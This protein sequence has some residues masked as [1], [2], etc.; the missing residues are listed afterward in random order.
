MN[1]SRLLMKVAVGYSLYSRPS[2]IPF[3]VLRTRRAE[4]FCRF[5]TDAGVRRR[6]EQ[7]YA[8]Q[9]T[10]RVRLVPHGITLFLW[11]ATACPCSPGELRIARIP[12]KGLPCHDRSTE[13]Q[14]P[15]ST[16]EFFL[17]EILL[18]LIWMILLIGT[19]SPARED[20][21]PTTAG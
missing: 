4:A 18:A 16:S 3:R 8:W 15:W 20:V 10:D 19:L 17:S 14:S 21:A 13:P 7:A 9:D 5:D 11:S 6:R 12:P 2:R 1:R